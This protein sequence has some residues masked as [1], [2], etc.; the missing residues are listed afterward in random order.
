MF[1]S[2]FDALAQENNPSFGVRVPNSQSTK[3]QLIV[4]TMQPEAMVCVRDLSPMFNMA[5]RGAV[6]QCASQRLIACFDA[7]SVTTYTDFVLYCNQG[8]R[9]AQT[10]FWYRIVVS[11]TSWTNPT[12]ANGT[13]HFDIFSPAMIQ[14]AQTFI[15]FYRKFH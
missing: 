12:D 2:S 15:I 6:N 3:I 1:V 10:D 7:S 8:C 14:F 11:S 5:A 4:E 9:S 13:W